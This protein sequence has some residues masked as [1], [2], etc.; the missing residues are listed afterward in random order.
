MQ[1]IANFRSG[2]YP[3]VIRSLECEVDH[4][5]RSSAGSIRSHYSTQIKTAIFGN[6][7][8]QYTKR[9]TD[10]CGQ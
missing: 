1:K 6:V 4:R 9:E 3:G 7:D 8:F 10:E 5:I 2:S